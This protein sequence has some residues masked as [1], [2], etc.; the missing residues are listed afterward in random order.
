MND[1]NKKY[2]LWDCIRVPIHHAPF[3][4]SIC[5]IQVI[6]S[7]LVPT[8]QIMVN[9]A[10][11]NKTISYFNGEAELT[12]VFIQ[13]TLVIVLIAYQWLSGI[14]I[15]KQ[16]L[17][18]ELRLMQ[19]LRIQVLEKQ[20]K[21]EYKHLEDPK[22]RDLISRVSSN[23][24]SRFLQAFQL[25]MNSF[26]LI[27]RIVGVLV[28]ILAHV[29]WAAIVILI[30]SLPMFYM[31]FKGSKIS[32]EVGKEVT[33]HVRRHSYLSGLLMGRDSADERNMF[34]YKDFVFKKWQRHYEEARQLEFKTRRKWFVKLESSSVATAFV[35]IGIIGVLL[36]PV[37]NGDLS[38]GIFASLIQAC[39]S[40]VQI[41]SWDL[42]GYVD[43]L[44]TTNEYIKEYTKFMQ[45]TE[46]DDVLTEP[47]PPFKFESLIL[48]NVSFKYPGTDT[49]ILKNLSLTI[50]NNKH[51]AFVGKNGSGKT[52]VVKL[53]T[54]LYSSYEGLICLNGKD[55]REFSHKELKSVY[56]AIFQDYA[57]YGLTLRENIRI[58]NINQKDTELNIEDQLGLLHLD[59][60]ICKLPDGLDSVLGRMTE[61]GQD[62]SGGQWQR[63]AIARSM[64]S[65]S[66]VKILDEPTAALDPVAE[67][68]IYQ[69][70]GR[71]TNNKTT[72]FISHRL[73]S[74]KLADFIYVF[75][76]GNIIEQG[77]H[78][79][80]MEQR[81]VYHEMYEKQ[82]GWY[83]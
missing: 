41:M 38:F 36:N 33:Q 26:S 57:Q 47:A 79:V 66:P 29:W 28:I 27:I 62:L 83:R 45:L 61:K 51:Y 53:I 8:I 30:F 77:S 13:L 78:Q 65:A 11:I 3:L 71:I 15:G 67:S 16:W 40:I 56:S 54:G 64:V 1:I 6:I 81:G 25:L 12:A 76:N 49:Y 48:D 7:S 34:D 2:T 22:M 55:I 44:V 35:S 46:E 32:Y 42:S 63:V 20:A 17:R 37:I 82:A 73:G 31:S 10:F 75:E 50:E 19:T 5:F 39:F 14:L 4:C 24:E 70:F 68:E 52:T 60:L 21:L 72:I 69:E 74:T 59:D 58:G 18:I 9:A 80:L 23:P 43:G